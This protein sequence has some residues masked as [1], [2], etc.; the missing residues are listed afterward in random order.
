MSEREVREQ[1]RRTRAAQMRARVR[2]G[3]RRRAALLI[4]AAAVIAV[5]LVAAVAVPI[6]REQRQQAQ[7]AATANAPI[8]GV[9]TF[10]ELSRNHVTTPVAY[11][12][13]LPVGGDHAPVWT[14]CGVYAD[15]V[16]PTEAVHS[17][18]HGAVWIGYRSDLPADQ[19][20]RLSAL[21][22]G[23]SYVLL[24][25]VQELPS[26]IAVSAWGAQISLDDAGDPRLATFVRKYQQGPQ[27]PEPG[28]PCS[29]GA[30]AMS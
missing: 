29:G 20:Q 5:G 25:P 18:E 8:E 10:S 12:Q 15:A 11:P 28:A 9:Q 17:L 6:V 14:D 30:G 23:N 2:R 1:A 27:T 13:A 3:E 24:S 4:A 16:Q 21:A 7:E 22:E 26:P 19:V